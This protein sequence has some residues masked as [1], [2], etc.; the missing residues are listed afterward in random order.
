MTIADRIKMVEKATDDV[1]IY[2]TRS[3][4]SFINILDEE[5]I[6]KIQSGDFY[7]EVFEEIDHYFDRRTGIYVKPEIPFDDFF[8]DLYKNKLWVTDELKNFIRDK[9]DKV[10]GYKPDSYDDDDD[11]IGTKVIDMEFNRLSGKIMFTISLKIY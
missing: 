3:V 2:T 8:I 9:L 1:C 10:W 5:I 7:I 6:K 11:G 4:D